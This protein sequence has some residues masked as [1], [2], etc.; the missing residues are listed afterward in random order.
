MSSILISHRGNL[1]GR[2][3]ERENHPDYIHEAILAGFDVE[4]DLWVIDGQLFLGHDKP[5]HP[6]DFAYLL[7]KAER[8]WVHAKDLQALELVGRDPRFNAFCH[9]NDPRTL[10]T[11]GQVWTRSI[12][13][14]YDANSVILRLD[15]AIIP[16]PNCAGLCTNFPVRYRSDWASI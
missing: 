16:Q 2:L 13:E 5:R 14:D 9:V 15:Y 3:P 11:K 4:I 12:D 7:R 10:T 1:N 6:V 8:L